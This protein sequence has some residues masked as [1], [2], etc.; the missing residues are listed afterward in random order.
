VDVHLYG[1]IFFG[2]EILHGQVSLDDDLHVG[3]VASLAT[4]MVARLLHRQ[5]QPDLHSAV[6][7]VVVSVATTVRLNGRLVHLNTV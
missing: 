5:A 7:Y 6:S 4:S 3:G 2:Y 1:E